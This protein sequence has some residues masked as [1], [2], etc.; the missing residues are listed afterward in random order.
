[1]TFACHRCSFPC[2]LLSILRYPTSALILHTEGPG[3]FP[4]WRPRLVRAAFPCR[5][6]LFLLPP[7]WS[8]RSVTWTVFCWAEA[9]LKIAR[10]TL[11]IKR[12][13]NWSSVQLAN[14]APPLSVTDSTIAPSARMRSQGHQALMIRKWKQSAVLFWVQKQKK[15]C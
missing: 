9:P 11:T 10:M 1:M 14:S 13:G 2:A 12:D 3:Y 4:V 5:I 15:H 6:L 7:S 8:K